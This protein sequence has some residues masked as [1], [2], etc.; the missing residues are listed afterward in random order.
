MSIFINILIKL[1]NC[2]LV[3]ITNEQ[4]YRESGK[5]AVNLWGLN[6]LLVRN[7]EIFSQ[8]GH[9]SSDAAYSS[10]TVVREYDYDAYGNEISY[11]NDDN[12]Y[13]YCSEYYDDESGIVFVNSDLNNLLDGIKSLKRVGGNSY[14]YNTYD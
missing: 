6:G 10:E 2:F 13:R 3:L 5:T 14:Q 4:Y 12:P 9:G 7:D 1:H 11:E 8:D